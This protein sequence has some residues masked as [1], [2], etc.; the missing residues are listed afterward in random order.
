MASV[1]IV[2]GGLVGCLSALRIAQAGARVTVLERAVP[3]A[4]AS[5]AAAGILAAHSEAAGPGAAYDLG[6]ESL[7]LYARLADELRDLVGVDVEYRRCGVLEIARDETMLDELDRKFAWQRVAGRTVE[8]WDAR[9]AHTREPELSTDLAGGLF[10]ADDGQIDPRRLVSAVSQAAERAGVIFRTGAYVRRVRREGDRVVGVELE[11][12]F[13][14][15]DHVVVAAGA[16]SALV[17]GSVAPGSVRPARGQ[18]VELL[19]RTP[20]LASVIYGGGGYVVPRRDG[21]VLCGSTLEFVGYQKDVTAAGVLRI[22]QMATTVVPALALARVGAA[23]SNFRPHTADMTPLVGDVGVRGLTVATGHFRS[24][25]LLAPVTA[26]IVR[27][28]VVHGR[29]SRDVSSWSA[30]RVPSQTPPTGAAA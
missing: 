3:G 28:L 10:F 17:E 6:C 20:P 25:I 12:D 26:E 11:D 16:W 8:R 2:G 23:W 13:V 29:T 24:G 19:C 9:L 30:N 15:A 18:I 14:P 22:L 7:G 1:L 21:R 4:E 27:D 5:S